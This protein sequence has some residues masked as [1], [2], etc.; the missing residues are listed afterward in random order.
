MLLKEKQCNIIILKDKNEFLS[1]LLQRRLKGVLVYLK[2]ENVFI[3][4][5]SWMWHVM[6]LQN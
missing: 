2:K 3:H 5:D 6:N 1:Y 4:R